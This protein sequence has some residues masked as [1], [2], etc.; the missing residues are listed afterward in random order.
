[1]ARYKADKLR[2]Q[3]KDL[4]IMISIVRDRLPGK[5]KYLV[6]KYLKMG[7]I[8]PEHIASP[9]MAALARL[10]LRARRL[11]SEIGLLR[12]A[13]QTR[14]ERRLERFLY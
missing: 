10:Y 13:S 2:E 5:A 11:Q 4:L 8:K 7:I 6:L 1:M 9:D 14:K 12:A 3:L